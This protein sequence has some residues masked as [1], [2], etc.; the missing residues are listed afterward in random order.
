MN[1]ARTPAGARRVMFRR[2]ADCFRPRQRVCHALLLCLVVAC[3]APGCASLRAPVVP[4]QPPAGRLGAVAAARAGFHAVYEGE[5]KIWF[6]SWRM[7][8]YV[9]VTPGGTN[10][11]VAV[12]SP[13]GMKIMQMQGT[14]SRPLCTVA[15]PAADRLKPY[16]EALWTGL[17]WSLADGIAADTTRWVRDGGAIEGEAVR[18]AFR[19]TYHADAATGALL[20]TEVWEGSRRLYDIR[21]ADER[22]DGDRSYPGLIQLACASPRCRLTLKIK[23]LRWTDGAQERD[24]ATGQ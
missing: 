23:N 16:G 22:R 8:W 9:A 6:H 17:V 4:A 21:F 5:L 13:A 1:T 15:M 2:R 10:L 24:D 12:L 19:V 11:S 3:L 7:I 14:Q 20:G 18:D